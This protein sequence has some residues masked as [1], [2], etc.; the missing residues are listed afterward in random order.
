MF[1]GKT[2]TIGILTG[3]IPANKGRALIEGKDISNEMQS[4]RQSL[5]VCPQVMT[6]RPLKTSPLPSLP[7][8]LVHYC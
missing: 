8:S 6:P 2:T 1:T 5:G 7:S 3:L 4:I